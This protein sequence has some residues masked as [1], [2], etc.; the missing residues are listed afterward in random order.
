MIKKLHPV[1]IV[2]Q[3]LSTN[4]QI[5]AGFQ[6]VLVDID[7]IVTQWNE[8][9]QPLIDSL[10]G[11]RR[12]LS[13]GDRTTDVN[14]VENGYDG[15]QVFMDMT[16]TPQILSG[17]LYNS[18]AKR[19]KTIKEVVV[20]S[21]V[22]LQSEMN[23]LRAL[24]DALELADSSYDDTNLK[25]WIRRLAAD[26]ISDLDQGDQFGTGYFGEPT[27]TVQ[28]SLHQRDVNL[29]TLIGIGEA[30]YGLT[31]PGFDGTNYIDDMDLID[32]L[33]ELD[34]R[35]ADAGP[36]PT[37]TLQDAYDNGDGAIDLTNSE[38][39]TLKTPADSDFALL[40]KGQM[41]F[42]ADVGGDLD[43]AIY[44][45]KSRYE[46]NIFTL[47]FH[48][49]GVGVSDSSKSLSL[50]CNTS[51]NRT[52]LRL[53]EGQL[54]N[55]IQAAVISGGKN[56]DN[57]TCWSLGNGAGSANT[58]L[59]A[60]GDL[61]ITTGAGLN[62][63]PTEDSVFDAEFFGTI[64]RT[65]KFQDTD[66]TANPSYVYGSIAGESSS[67][68]RSSS[69]APEF[70]PVDGDTDGLVASFAAFQPLR[71]APHGQ[72]GLE[73]PVIGR[74]YLDNTAKALLKIECDTAIGGAFGRGDAIV[75]FNVRFNDDSPQGAT[76]YNKATGELV[77]EFL[78][79]M[80]Q[81]GV[82]TTLATIQD[83][84]GDV[85]SITTTNTSKSSVTLLIKKFS[86]TAWTVPNSDFTI[87]VQVM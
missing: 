32:A 48:R 9:L 74:L 25:N 30:D 66:N 3:S 15:S 24:V 1:A 57:F 18:R 85:F 45:L 86:G 71:R 37:T 39:L 84:N 63:T 83:S 35:V 21:H 53:G 4:E 55:E 8:T 27:K 70:P 43:G 22:S 69:F 75:A 19:P 23:K 2:P 65:L 17:F 68:L 61:T 7:A 72:G 40:L 77:I 10:P 67:F 14:P 12:R 28:Y 60:S 51:L 76:T 56:T 26:T 52:N 11:G 5:R 49:G 6:E 44:N 33:V 54:A 41:Q 36:N 62:F 82:Y 29:R 59:L 87:S 20:D 80:H 73:D 79:E 42:L 16:S 78:T 46:T 81:S 47:D 50:I 31:N 38:P 13:P 58:T 34:G 64:A